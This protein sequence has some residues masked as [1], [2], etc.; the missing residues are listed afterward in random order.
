VRR[1]RKRRKQIWQYLRDRER[2][3]NNG[4]QSAQTIV[5]KGAVDKPHH[6]GLGFATEN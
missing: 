3:A 6:F 1:K 5:D 2:K 4:P